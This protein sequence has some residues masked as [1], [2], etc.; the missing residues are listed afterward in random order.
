M[1]ALQLWI[2]LS[3]EGPAIIISSTFWWVIVVVRIITGSETG[4]DAA[5]TVIC[6]SWEP[7]G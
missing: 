2:P 5:K 3:A 6:S 1:S 4:G 7:S